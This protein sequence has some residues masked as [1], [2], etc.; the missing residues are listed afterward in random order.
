VWRCAWM[1]FCEVIWAWAFQTSLK[2]PLVFSEVVN[3][4]LS[5]PVTV[6][7]VHAVGI[8]FHRRCLPGKLV[9]VTRLGGRFGVLVLNLLEVVESVY[10]HSQTLGMPKLHV[11]V[12]FL[13]SSLN[14][15]PVGQKQTWLTCTACCAHSQ[16]SGLDHP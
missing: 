8:Q 7:P 12:V 5:W 11:L 10:C 13:H 9:N 14:G 16:S 4:W 6:L 1:W 3:E 15:Q 2:R